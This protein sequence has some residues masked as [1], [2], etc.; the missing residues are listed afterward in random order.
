MGVDDSY[1]IRVGVLLDGGK[2]EKLLTVVL[3]GSC[4]D[5]V[6]EMILVVEHGVALRATDY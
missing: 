1:K 2:S 4:S 3:E 5:G 6:D